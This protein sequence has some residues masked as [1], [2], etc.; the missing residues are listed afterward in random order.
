MNTEAHAI[1]KKMEE[2]R[3]QV[4]WKAPQ[5]QVD[6]T[7]EFAGLLVILADESAKSAAKLERFTRWLVGL[8]VALLLLT[9]FLCW[10]AYESHKHID[11]ENNTVSHD[12]K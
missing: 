12:S 6:L 1:L 2:L 3:P 4:G 9:A 8:T 7:I 10:D 5:S 11:R